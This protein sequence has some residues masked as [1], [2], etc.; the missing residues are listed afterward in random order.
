[1][2]DLIVHPADKPLVGSVPV[3]SDK[4]IG[5]RALLFS[6]LCEG[7]SRIAAFS[8][9]EDNVSTANAMRAMGVTIRETGPSD[10]VVTGVE[11][12]RQVLVGILV[13]PAADLGVHAGDARRRLAQPLAV[14]VL[15]DGQQDLADG[16]AEALVIDRR[17][18][19]G[20][21]I[22]NRAAAAAGGPA[23]AGRFIQGRALSAVTAGA[24]DA[25]ALL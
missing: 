4:S 12:D 21:R 16:P 25:R 17:R 18:P 1:M 8:H 24:P 3:P 11:R 22:G 14:G 13:Q 6:A 5:H 23:R 7:E 20:G 2:T 19:V 10:L 9:G 15:A